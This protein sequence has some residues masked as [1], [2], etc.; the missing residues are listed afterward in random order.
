MRLCVFERQKC[1]MRNGLHC[2]WCNM[3]TFSRICYVNCFQVDIHS[4]VS[5]DDRTYGCL[6]LCK[7]K[8]RI[9]NMFF[10]LSEVRKSIQ[11]MAMNCNFM[12]CQIL[13]IIDPI[14]PS[15]SICLEVWSVLFLVHNFYFKPYLGIILKST[16]FVHCVQ[17]SWE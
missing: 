6:I 13:Y 16:F 11:K 1:L 8:A 5:I 14:E 3:M 15:L 10:I 9:R 17:E 12:T 7:I 2:A 4:I